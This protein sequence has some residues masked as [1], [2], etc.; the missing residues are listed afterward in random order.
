MWNIQIIL[1]SQRDTSVCSQGVLIQNLNPPMQ[2]MQSS[3]FN[4]VPVSHANC[5]KQV[6]YQAVV[7]CTALC[8]QSSAHHWAFLTDYTGTVDSGIIL[9]VHHHGSE[10]LDEVHHTHKLIVLKLLQP[11]TERVTHRTD[12]NNMPEWSKTLRS[13]ESSVD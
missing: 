4:I 9:L 10:P 1:A 7:L 2:L 6:H 3:A 11:G 12:Q 5:I 13:S 8:M